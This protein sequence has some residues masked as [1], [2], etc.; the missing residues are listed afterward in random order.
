M[1]CPKCQQPTLQEQYVEGTDLI[2]NRCVRCKGI[3][4]DRGELR[5]VIAE[6]DSEL[7]IPHKAVRLQARCPKCDK[8]L[9]AFH[10]PQTRVTIEVCKRCAGIWLDAGEISQIREAR[11]SLPLQEEP[12]E[13]PEVGG[14]KG[15]L[16]RL[17][18]QA[19]DELTP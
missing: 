11:Q 2:A 17:I 16:I 18:D 13:Q 4:F 19:I 7:P 8:P 14:V 10:Y 15:A 1:L 9:Y 5:R 6:A 12:T 3:W